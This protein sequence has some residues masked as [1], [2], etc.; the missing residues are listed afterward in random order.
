MHLALREGEAAGG[1][2]VSAEIVRLEQAQDELLDRLILEH[3]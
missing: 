1:R 2:E 3:D